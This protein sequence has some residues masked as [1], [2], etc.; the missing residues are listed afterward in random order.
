MFNIKTFLLIGVTFSL[1]ACGGSNEDQLAAQRKAQMSQ[2]L[3]KMV[4]SKSGGQGMSMF[5]IPASDDYAN[6][7][8]DPNNTITAEKVALGQ[9]LYHETAVSTASTTG[10]NGTYSCASCHHVKA[11]FKSGVPQGLADGG[12]GFGTSGEGRVA[13]S[14]V[15]VADID[16]QDLTSPAVLNVAYQ[17]VMLWNGAFGKASGSI[18][19]AVAN[20]DN[21][22]PANTFANAFGLSG[23]ETQVI[24]GTRVHRLNFES[25]SIVDS[26]LEYT[27][28]YNAAFPN[29]ASECDVSLGSAAGSTVTQ[30]S[31]CA[32]KAIAAYE[33]TILA[34]ESPFQ[35]WLKGDT[36][37]MSEAEL[38]GAYLFF[39]KANCVACHTGPALSSDKSATAEQMFFALGFNDFDLS[40]S[41]IHGT[42]STNASLGRGGFTGVATDNFKFKV[43]QLYNLLDSNVFGHGASFTS[44]RD[45][46]AYKN[47]A[48]KQKVTATNIAAEF[49]PLGLTEA[50]IDDLTSFLETGLY[51]SNLERYVPSALPSG[52][53]FPVNDAQSITDLGC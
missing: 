21:F 45:V 2:D 19:T 5:M 29:P 8:Q 16:K 1:F 50:E 41:R 10:R 4:V 44:V 42:V 13:A 20:V 43:P 24:A 14:G 36:N 53:C 33:R 7:P 18:N 3:E 17:D 30:E 25:G 35:K 22:G 6:I 23:I 47:A 31:L 9:L 32:A 38:R 28:K 34:N 37:A 11:G 49:V 51:D 26:N 12:E 40:D 48:V 46:V 52:N 15:T 39:G 27:S